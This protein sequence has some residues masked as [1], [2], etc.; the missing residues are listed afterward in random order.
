MHSDVIQRKI[1]PHLSAN[2]MRYD[3]LILSASLQLK[4]YYS[5]DILV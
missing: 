2:F 4:N 1:Q 5:L 3:L